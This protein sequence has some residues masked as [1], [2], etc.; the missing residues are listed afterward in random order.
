VKR[1]FLNVLIIFAVAF[2]VFVLI[3]KPEICKTGAAAGILLCGRVIIPSLFP[4][5]MCV[6]FIIN[7][8]ILNSLESVFKGK[9]RIDILFITLLS[10][11]GGY[12]I[13]AKLLSN[14][15]IQKKLSKNE[16]SNM[17]NHSINAGPAFIIS[18]VGSGI[19]NSKL[20]GAIL[21]CSHILSALMLIPLSRKDSV[22]TA[23]VTPHKHSRINPADNFVKS[24]AEASSTVLNICSF[25]ILFSCINA[26]INH[27][28]DSVSEARIIGLLLEITNALTLTKNIYII[29][30][31]LGFGGISIW[32]QVLSIGKGLE[33]KPLKFILFRILHGVLSVGFTAILLKL[34]PLSISVFSN[35][36]S[37]SFSYFH[38]TAAVGISL[39]AMAI[40]FIISITTKKYAGKIIEDMI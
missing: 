6:I 25:T 2:F 20:A 16:A 39:L 13:G 26:Y 21:L 29:S 14:E 3:L 10:F 40:V 8:D 19:L 15:V 36:T 30:F 24:V 18:A 33:I 22:N 28:S 7:S 12:P 9:F 32:C 17:L 5:T 27:L 4:F 11:I 37:T 34:F 23:A 38:S 31:L 1:R 35:V